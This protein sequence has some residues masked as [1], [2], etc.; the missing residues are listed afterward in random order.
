MSLRSQH[1]KDA[2]GCP[3][4]AVYVAVFERLNGCRIHQAAPVADRVEHIPEIAVWGSLLR[5]VGIGAKVSY[6]ISFSI[7]PSSISTYLIHV[8]RLA[9]IKCMV[10]KRATV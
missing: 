8:H 4:A 6:W 9:A 2:L 5:A 7:T 1:T 3:T 10:P